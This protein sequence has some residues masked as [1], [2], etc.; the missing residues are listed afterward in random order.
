MPQV[1]YNRL[2]KEVSTELPDSTSLKGSVALPTRGGVE[3]PVRL[4]NY[5]VIQKL[6]IQCCEVCG[7]TFPHRG[8]Y[9][10]NAISRT[11]RLF[12]H[13]AAQPS[14]ELPDIISRVNQSHLL[15][16]KAC[17]AHLPLMHAF[18]WSDC[19][20]CALI[21][22]AGFCTHVSPYVIGAFSCLHTR[23]Q[24]ATGFVQL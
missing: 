1:T 15:A 11:M 13:T 20:L 23:S 18:T 17:Q 9:T 24:Q 3:E 10:Y 16:Y 22:H 4:L 19:R 14:T 12:P 8:G 21:E 6:L 2:L 5:G 7:A